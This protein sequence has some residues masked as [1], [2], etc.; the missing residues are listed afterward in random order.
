MAQE[1]LEEELFQLRD[2]ELA[3]CVKIWEGKRDDCIEI[4]NEL[5][6]LIAC[7][8]EVP[9]LRVITEDLMQIFNEKP[10]FQ[11]WEEMN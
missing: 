1:H 3:L 5:I 10:L 8:H 9:Q 2:A 4:G 7:L 6:R 11:Y